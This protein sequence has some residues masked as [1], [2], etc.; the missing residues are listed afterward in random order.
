[1][2]LGTLTDIRDT[3]SNPTTVSMTGSAT[4]A[5]NAKY[6][7]RVSADSAGYTLT[8]AS[9]NSHEITNTGLNAI[10]LDTTGPTT[11]ALQPNEVATI[12]WDENLSTHYLDIRQ[13]DL[14]GTVETVAALQALNATD[15][16]TVVKVRSRATIGDTPPFNV[17]HIGSSGTDDDLSVFQVADGDY[18]QVEEGTTITP[19][20][21]GAIGQ[22]SIANA[23]SAG[24]VTA[25]I[26]KVFALWS[27]GT[28]EKIDSAKR[29]VYYYCPNGIAPIE[30]TGNGCE[31]NGNLVCDPDTG[32]FVQLK[33]AGTSTNRETFFINGIYANNWDTAPA[34]RTQSHIPDKLATDSAIGSQL[35][36][37]IDAGDVD[38]GVQITDANL[39][40]VRLG[41]IYGF[42]I[43][44]LFDGVLG[45]VGRASV[46]VGVF[47]NNRI[48]FAF[49]SRNANDGW[50]NENKNIENRQAS[51][52]ANIDPIGRDVVG[53]WFGND[54]PTIG[55]GN[56]EGYHPIDNIVTRMNFEFVPTTDTGGTAGKVIQTLFEKGIGNTVYLR[57]D[58]DKYIGMWCVDHVYDPANSVLNASQNE[59][60]TKVKSLV[61]AGGG[62]HNNGQN[63]AIYVAG[64]PTGQITAIKSY[65]DIGRHHLVPSGLADARFAGF[66]SYRPAIAGTPGNA[67]KQR[68]PSG[69]N[70]YHQLQSDP[71]RARMGTSYT[72][73]PG[74]RVDLPDLGDRFGY[75][76]LTG[77][78][79]EWRFGVTCLDS[80]GNHLHGDLDG[81]EPSD[82]RALLQ[83]VSTTRNSLYGI[84]LSNTNYTEAKTFELRLHPNTKTAVFQIW[85]TDV[86][87][88]ECR[89]I[90]IP[91]AKIYSGANT[92]LRQVTSLPKNG[93]WYKND[94]VWLDDGTDTQVEYRVKNDG[95]S[96]A[97]SGVFS[98]GMSLS[99]EGQRVHQ[100]TSSP[101]KIWE[102]TNFV[103]STAGT[104][105][106]SS[107]LSI[108]DTYIDSAANE[109][110][111][112][113]SN[114][115][116][117]TAFQSVRNEVTVTD[118]GA[119]GDGIT[120]DTLAIQAAI[121]AANTAGGGKL[122]FP[123]GTY[124]TGLLDISPGLILQGA[125][126]ES[127]MKLVD[128]SANFTRI[129][130]TENTKP[131]GLTSDT[132]LIV[133]KDL[134]FDGNKSNQTPYTGGEKENQSG[135]FI[136]GATDTT[137][138]LR[139]EI[140]RC[141][142]VNWAGDGIQLRANT[143]T[144][145]TSCKFD[146]NWRACLSAT[147]GHAKFSFSDI[148]MTGTTDTPLLDLEVDTAGFGASE[149]LVGDLKNVFIENGTIHLE[150][151]VGTNL[152]LNNVQTGR[153]FSLIG[154]AEKDECSIVCTD[155]RFG[156]SIAADEENQIRRA[157]N[158]KFVNTAFEAR[159]FG[160]ETAADSVVRIWMDG[161]S[162]QLVQFE[163]CS[164]TV[165]T[166][167]SVTDW[168]GIECGASA[169]DATNLLLIRNSRFDETISDYYYYLDRFG[170]PIE[171]EGG[172]YD[173]SGTPTQQFAYLAGDAT[174]HADIR[175]RNIVCPENLTKWAQ[176]VWNTSD[177]KLTLENV[178]VPESSNILSENSVGTID[179]WVVTG[180]RTIIGTTS[181]DQATNLDGI[182][183]D[184]WRWKK[185]N[186]QTAWF[187]CTAAHVSSPTW[188]LKEGTQDT[189]TADDAT[190]SVAGC[191]LIDT[192]ANTTDTNI[193]PDNELEGQ[194]VTIF[195]TNAN[196]SIV[197]G[198]S[199]RLNGQIDFQSGANGG[200]ITLIKKGSTWY[201]LGQSIAYA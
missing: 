55:F 35:A 97:T 69:L 12:V 15:M 48:Q 64:N 146:E 150:N 174:R 133:I 83:G 43:G 173:V 57:N 165:A 47:F 77:D 187:T 45:F 72:T 193:V 120:D 80:N 36:T 30:L 104:T 162:N 86:R 58:L 42:S 160:A 158:V 23:V 168:R 200:T 171:I 152:V 112:F 153:S 144:V 28:Y 201:E 68:E 39:P 101:Y 95:K 199:M 76:Q 197:H 24:D 163:N 63:N 123:P 81:G 25:V 106:D 188:A 17:R 70:A 53:C 145:V 75:I 82:G 164:F 5:A 38:V 132:D 85:G 155:C 2:D 169:N 147:A 137:H 73:S 141:T 140:T 1:M 107:G 111:Y 113:E 157:G 124:I 6:L 103:S 159:S 135:C 41:N 161:R 61:A 139:C 125:G 114:A 21:G 191:R 172:Q 186:N 49:L 13:V 14:V 102:L 194:I 66:D 181:P 37:D 180:G 46:E 178:H 189:A 71:T 27:A 182:D 93:I 170:S 88:I 117:I 84:E 115:D 34:W 18:Y 92:D 110:T 134:K 184:C 29:E 44:M 175:M 142:F 74:F 40:N 118:Y 100:G 87:A 128:S 122:V 52:S 138:R 51:I 192:S 65:Q 127:I 143:D 119:V 33:K 78:G 156:T 8:V 11:Q 148:R 166:A 167:G 179:N 108:G 183:G 59:V 109:W 176:F 131:T 50:V 60:Y 129:F 89:C 98:S 67:E 62:D 149:A 54:N 154:D 10:N 196:T 151:Q 195:C 94:S 56:D 90:D 91:G 32:T 126:D 9:G 3:V 22:T 96:Y 20:M 79:A 121:D 198:A 16:K 177:H 185:S 4:L 19:E 116:S 105:L 136:S 99:E 190:P 130:T 7:V 26:N 31:F